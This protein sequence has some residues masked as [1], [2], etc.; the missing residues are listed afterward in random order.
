VLP[1][2]KR[3][4]VTIGSPKRDVHGEITNAVLLLHG[5]SGTS[6]LWLNP[7]TAVPLFSPGKPLDA[8]KYF[9]IM[10]DGIGRGRSSKPSDGLKSK[11]PHYRYADMVESDYRLLTE[12]LGVK[13]LRLLLGVS[14]GGMQS[15]M[16]AEKHPDFMDAVVPL[17]A[18]PAPLAGRNWMMRQITINA[19]RSDPEWRGGD[20]DKPPSLWTKTAPA[21]R[22]MA[23]GT[24][25]LARMAPDVA[26]GRRLV[27]E[28]EKAAA[29]MDANDTLW[30]R[31]AAEDYDP[32]ADIGRIKARLLAIN[33][34]D[35]AVNPPELHTV[36]PV[37]SRIPHARYVLLPAG[38][39]SCGHQTYQI[40][41]MW[42]P[43]VGRF[44]AKV[45]R[46]QAR[47]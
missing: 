44:L 35:D 16:W 19:I 29:N 38:P 36:E 7:R 15:W 31:E 26:S 11:F 33:F 43:V 10:P 8:S 34:A 2:T 1:E 28:F 42:G 37:I 14:M 18:Q 47:P 46:R 45:P 40:S 41:E 6:S 23:D 17:A 24:V 39:L 30:S 32:T 9:I 4:Y 13:R 5:A 25:P 3:G 22:L 21:I 12:V 20:Y 27:E